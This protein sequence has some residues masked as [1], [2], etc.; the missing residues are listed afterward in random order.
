MDWAGLAQLFD[1]KWFISCV[2]LEEQRHRLI[3][4]HMET[5][6]EEKTKIWGDGKSGGAARKA[7]SNDLLN[8]E[9]VEFACKKYADKVIISE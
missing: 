1:E 8:A 3:K 9:F 6:T 2:T 4:R 7:D 5:W